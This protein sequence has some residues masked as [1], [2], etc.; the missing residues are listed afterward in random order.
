MPESWTLIANV[1][2]KV[3]ETWYGPSYGNE[4]EVPE[5]VARRITNPGVWDGGEAPFPATD[6]TTAVGITLDDSGFAVIDADELQDALQDTDDTLALLIGYVTAALTQGSGNATR[7]GALE[8]YLHVAV[9]GDGTSTINIDG[10]KQLVDIDASADPNIVLA[11]LGSTAGA[12]VLF[13]IF[14]TEDGPRVP[15]FTS[16]ADIVWDTPPLDYIPTGAMR[17]VLA[18]HPGGALGKWT[19][20]WLGFHGAFNANGQANAAATGTVEYGDAAVLDATVTGDLT[21]TRKTTHRAG[22]GFACD[23]VLTGGGSGD[24]SLTL[25]GVTWIGTPLATIVNGETYLVRVVSA[26]GGTHFAADLTPA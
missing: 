14:A 10:T 22:N 17:Q 13:T 6:P 1:R 25:T 23:L 5:A 12:A 11:A 8:T 21:L 19:L 20:S 18:K 2:D 15:S 4:T 24:H 16:T 7:A 3:T 9:T 26:K